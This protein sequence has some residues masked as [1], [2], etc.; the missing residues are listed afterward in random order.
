[1]AFEGIAACLEPDP[2]VAAAGAV[3][4]PAVDPQAVD[5]TAATRAA[6]RIVF[7]SR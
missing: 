3:A 1:M 7:A 6:H 4:S 5:P 2:G